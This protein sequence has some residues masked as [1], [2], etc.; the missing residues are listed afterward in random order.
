MVS[1]DTCR[2]LVRMDTAFAVVRHLTEPKMTKYM[3]LL[4]QALGDGEQHKAA[5]DGNGG[6]ASEGTGLDG[7]VQAF[8]IEDMEPVASLPPAIGDGLRLGLEVGGFWFGR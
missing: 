5:E 1:N 4:K 3:D 6:S 2:W 7:G 8:P